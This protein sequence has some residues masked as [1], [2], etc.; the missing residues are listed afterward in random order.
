MK[1]LSA[2][3]VKVRVW[4]GARMPRLVGLY[5]MLWEVAVRCTD[6]QTGGKPPFERGQWGEGGGHCE[7]AVGQRTDPLG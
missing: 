1:R 7:K 5:P 4:L 3:G 2:A 6:V